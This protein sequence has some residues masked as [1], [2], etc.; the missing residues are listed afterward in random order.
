MPDVDTPRA[1]GATVGRE[2]NIFAVLPDADPAEVCRIML[3]PRLLGQIPQYKWHVS[4]SVW[5]ESPFGPGDGEYEGESEVTLADLLKRVTDEMLRTYSA[6]AN[7]AYKVF[8]WGDRID[9]FILFQVQ[10]GGCN[11]HPVH[12]MM[13]LS[14]DGGTTGC[15]SIVGPEIP[16]FRGLVTCCDNADTDNPEDL[17]CLGSEECEECEWEVCLAAS[18]YQAAHLPGIIRRKGMCPVDEFIAAHRAAVLA[19]L[20]EGASQPLAIPV[21]AAVIADYYCPRLEAPHPI[22]DPTEPSELDNIHEQLADADHRL[23]LEHTQRQREAKEKWDLIRARQTVMDSRRIQSMKLVMQNR[24]AVKTSSGYRRILTQI[25]AVP[26][27]ERAAIVRASLD[28][29]NINDLEADYL[30]EHCSGKDEAIGAS[31]LQGSDA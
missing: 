9:T 8:G 28:S 10:Q 18:R 22:S 29:G 4:E 30:F 15:S 24:M 31:S 1:K 17:G 14:T 19:A 2:Y 20:D 25:C 27:R 21:I 7:R 5:A 12:T 26:L 13:C 16:S 6:E 23:D 11:C 3:D